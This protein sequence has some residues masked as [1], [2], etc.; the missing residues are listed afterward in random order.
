MNLPRW[1]LRL[2]PMWTHICP[3]CKGEVKANSHKCPH[4]GEQYPMA[5]RV[6]PKFL[7]DKKALEDYVHKNVFPRVDE[8]T[9]KYLT[10]Y[11]TVLFSDGFESGDFSAWTGVIKQ[12]GGTLESVIA[13]PVHHG[14]YSASL[15]RDDFYNYVYLYKDLSS[16]YSE[17]YMRF[18]FRVSGNQA[19]GWTN[20]IAILGNSIYGDI[21]YAAVKDD[22]GTLRFLLGCYNGSGFSEA[23]LSSES[24]SFD[25]WYCVELKCVVDSTAGES[26]LFI[27]GAEKLSLTGLTNNGRDNLNRVYL[28]NAG[29]GLATSNIFDCVVG[30]DAAVG[31]EQEEEL[32]NISV[33]DTVATA[34]GLLADKTLMQTDGVWSTDG[35]RLDWALVVG[36]GVF[37]AEAVEVGKVDRRTRLFLVLGA[38]S[39]QLTPET[40]S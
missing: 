9:R 28:T 20:Q 34:D 3:K 38:V 15:F 33:T 11:F 35:L 13:S 27:D 10:Q 39:V 4:C 19:F 40:S 36:D 25:T 30:A 5:L 32:T 29:G 1:L 22:S 6:P 24:V 21:A 17:L 7:K 26:R 23:T 12:S 14:N 31:V 16:S 37:V 8:E 2:L 18:Y